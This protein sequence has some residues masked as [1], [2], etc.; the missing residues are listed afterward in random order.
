[1]KLGFLF[2]MFFCIVSVNCAN[3]ESEKMTNIYPKILK[4]ADY[5]NLSDSMTLNDLEK[6]DVTKLMEFFN[7][8]NPITD[9]WKNKNI[10]NLMGEVSMSSI[11]KGIFS[12][13]N[14]I[15]T[16]VPG[17]DDIFSSLP[18][19]SPGCKTILMELASP[20]MN[21]TDISNV[22]PVLLELPLGKSRSF[23]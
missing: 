17:R 10:N 18:G 12:R 16:F 8:S 1:M 23:C 3:N 5:L 19:I 11:I 22:I 9:L 21:I 13:R 7:I 2:V 6:I 4:I 20:L 15:F 14:E